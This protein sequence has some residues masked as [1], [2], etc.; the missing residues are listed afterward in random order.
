VPID[1]AHGSGVFWSSMRALK[2]LAVAVVVVLVACKGKSP[3]PWASSGS[4]APTVSAKEAAAAPAP[5][6]ED[7]GSAVAEPAPA[8]KT[9]DGPTFTITS[10]LPGPDTKTKDIDTDSGKTTM[11]MYEFADP[12]DDDTMQ[13]V[14]SN[15]VGVKV[16]GA[17]VERVL[18]GS[19]S[20]MTDNLKAIIDD[21]KT[22]KVGD[23]SMLDFSSHFSAEG[24]DY[25]FRGRVAF[26]GGQ[27]YQVA[28]MGKGTKAS[29]SAETFVT[30]FRLK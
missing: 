28:A 16:T 5:V 10:T 11:T 6:A 22:V 30:S 27:L 4:A 12:S 8:A 25:F 1:A 21:K 18:E 26:K 9:Y 14:E 17:T 7:K 29:A 20:G 3:S 15:E 13:M 24:T 2:C 23:D 19:M